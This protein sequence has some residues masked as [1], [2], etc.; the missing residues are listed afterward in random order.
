MKVE[1]LMRV[2]GSEI[3]ELSVVAQQYIE[4]RRAA[5]KCLK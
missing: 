2:Q 4:A 3:I 5:K 1:F